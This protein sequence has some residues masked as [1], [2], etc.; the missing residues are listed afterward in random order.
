MTRYFISSRHSSGDK[1]LR[2][3]SLQV[4][5]QVISNRDSLYNDMKGQN[6]ENLIRGVVY[7]LM[8]YITWD[9]SCTICLNS[10][11]MRVVN[12]KIVSLTLSR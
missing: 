10:V 6:V 7:G 1:N 3:I 8:H 4:K 2:K 11:S 12:K 5:G 9:Y